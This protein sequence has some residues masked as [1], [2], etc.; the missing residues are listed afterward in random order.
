[1]R[2]ILLVEDE[3][4]LREV[5]LDILS[6]QPYICDF[7][8]NGKE[9][10]EKCQKKEYDLILL[11]IMMP[12]M[13]GIDFLKNYQKTEQMKNKIIIMSNL[14]SGKEIESAHSLGIQK[15][16]LK[17]DISPTQLIAAVRYQLAA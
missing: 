5:Y 15:T 6:T 10:L 4:I 12:I 1:M 9:A 17:S 16:I 13:N 11:D 2:K 14:S 3:T 7:A 8:E